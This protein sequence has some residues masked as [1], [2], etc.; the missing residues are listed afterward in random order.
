MNT[1]KIK[2]SP[3]KLALISFAFL[4][5]AVVGGFVIYGLLTKDSY[6][7]S[8]S[9]EKLSGTLTDEQLLNTALNR[10]LTVKNLSYDARA[11][12]SFTADVKYILGNTPQLASHTTYTDQNKEN[13]TFDV[14]QKDK[15]MYFRYTTL[16][17]STKSDSPQTKFINKWILVNEETSKG[18][19]AGSE[20]VAMSLFAGSSIEVPI[21]IGNAD[22]K[23][24]DLIQAKID[25]GYYKIKSTERTQYRGLDAVKFTLDVDFENASKVFREIYEL[26]DKSPIV[27][28]G[29][30]ISQMAWGMANAY[31][32]AGSSVTLYVSPVNGQVFEISRVLDTSSYAVLS[33]KTISYSNLRF[34]NVALPA[35]PDKTIPFNQYYK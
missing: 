30:M 18:I 20:Y 35:V 15:S 32:R 22:Q 13:T 31:N 14:I 10:L 16:P 9:F 1:V 6:G 28:G 33:A 27:Q 4:L 26:H 11:E 2:L 3:V 23:I 8:S 21:V 5:L 12:G 29:I 19:G 25:A 24:K 34:N 7:L 17:A